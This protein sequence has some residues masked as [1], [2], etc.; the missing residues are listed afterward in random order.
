M[1]QRLQKA[2]EL[3]PKTGKV[4][5]VIVYRVYH[6]KNDFTEGS[7]ILLD[8]KIILLDHQ[9][10]FIGILKIMNVAKDVDI[11]AT[12]LNI[13]RNYFNKMF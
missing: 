8:P 4:A 1:V 6:E 9:N 12:S 2:E 11:L 13:L 7:K 5:T 3:L 10:N